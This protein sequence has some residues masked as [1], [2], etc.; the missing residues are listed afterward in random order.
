MV[1]AFYYTGVSVFIYMVLFFLAAL[2]LKNNSIVDFGWGGGF[3][4]VAFLNLLLAEKIYSRQI[5]ISLLVLIWGVRLILH[6]YRRNK[7]K[8]EDYRYVEMRNRWGKNVVIKSFLYVFMLQGVLLLMISYP[9][10]MVNVFPQ[11]EIG[12]IDIFGIIVW[13]IGF[14]FETISD[15]QLWNFIHFEKKNKEEVM[16][17]GLW[18]FSR[19]PNYFGES[20][21]WWGIFFIILNVQNGIFAIF[22]PALITLLLLKV[23]GV[24]LLEK[25]YANNKSFQEYAKRTSKFIPW[26]PK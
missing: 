11:T 1:T 21:L 7:G 15:N 16:T 9:L 17:K 26:F 10:I 25:R 14:L 18:R 20:L 3:V 6:I 23:S 19:H 8:P 24:P 2:K 5:L 22:S 12:L 4:L 13:L